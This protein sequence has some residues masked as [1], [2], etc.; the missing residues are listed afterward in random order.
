ML[1]QG[2]RTALSLERRLDEA[3]V[4][5]A[6]AVADEPDLDVEPHPLPC[7]NRALGEDRPKN[8]RF[9]QRVGAP[10]DAQPRV[11]ASGS[12][13]RLGLVFRV[14]GVESI[15][16][17][18]SERGVDVTVHNSIPLLVRQLQVILVLSLTDAGAPA[19]GID[20]LA[21]RVK[22]LGMQLGGAWGHVE[23][24]QDG[25]RELRVGTEDFGGFE[26]ELDL[27][28]GYHIWR[29]LRF[30]VDNGGHSEQAV[31]GGVYG[32]SEFTGKA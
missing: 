22:K 31:R 28:V 3:V 18:R 2:Y 29:S 19:G 7:A 25:A 5:R 30:G 26:E 10:V 14:T 21:G 16:I 4:S 24:R 15:N 8:T 9:C 6:R 1:S 13:I 17:S 12:P 11:S 20:V 23:G 32:T 27:V